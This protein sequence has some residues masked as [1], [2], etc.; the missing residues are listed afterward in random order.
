MEKLIRDL[1]DL[2][3]YEALEGEVLR[4]LRRH[5]ARKN[6]WE[7]RHRVLRVKGKI[8][9]VATILASIA[10]I[11]TDPVHDATFAILILPLA[12]YLIVNGADN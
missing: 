7:H 2:E 5:R 3:E 11:V 4:N 12:V 8:A 9:G 6:A 10:M 1:R